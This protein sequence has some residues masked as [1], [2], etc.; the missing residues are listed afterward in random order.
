MSDTK[1]TEGLRPG[2]Q[3]GQ[4]GN[5]KGRPKGSRNRV[6]VV[7]LAAMEE[8]ADAIARKVVDMA[9]QGD[10]SAARL[11]LERLVPPA[12][13]RPVY[14]ELPDMD[15][16]AGIAEAQQAVLQAVADGELLPGEAATL[17]GIVEARRK[18]VETLELEQRITALEGK[19]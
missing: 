4:S 11:V 5:P 3:P 19:K 1:K 14:L 7:A 13:E 18:A 12:K 15:T 6:T 8:G 2:W 10:M 9:K 17:A 16:A